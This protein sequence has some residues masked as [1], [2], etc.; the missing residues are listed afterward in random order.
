MNLVLFLDY[1]CNNYPKFLKNSEDFKAIFVSLVDSCTFVSDDK[2]LSLT[3]EVYILVMQKKA[4]YPLFTPN[5]SE[6]DPL[7]IFNVSI[8]DPVR[9]LATVRLLGTRE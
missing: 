1:S 3:I 6:K 8:F 9:L 4:K 7:I 5:L 2:Y